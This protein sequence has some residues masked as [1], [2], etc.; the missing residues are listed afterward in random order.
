MPTILIVIQL[1]WSPPS[2]RRTVGLPSRLL[3]TTSMWPLLKRS[4]KAVPRL[5]RG[6]MRASPVCAA[7]SVKVPSV[8]VEKQD[9]LR[10]LRPNVDVVHLRVDV[11]IHDHQVRPAVV[12]VVEKGSPPAHPGSP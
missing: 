12:V 5:T 4:P 2:L 9:P 7:T 10:V 6:T 11:A 1:L 8:V 3:M